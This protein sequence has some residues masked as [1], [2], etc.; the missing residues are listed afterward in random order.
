MSASRKPARAQRSAPTRTAEQ[1]ARTD[2]GPRPLPPLMKQGRTRQLTLTEVTTPAGLRVI[3][4]RKPGAP[5]IEVRLRIPFAARSGH[6]AA[7]HAARAEV[8]AETILL[9]TAD[10]DRRRIDT[11][12]G[13]VGGG[14]HAAVDPQR[15]SLAGSV[16][17]TGLPVLARILALSLTGAAYRAGD[18]AGERERLVEHL[19]IST[20]QP[21]VIARQALLRKRFGDHPAVYEMPSGPDVAAVGAAAVRGL[22]RRAV[23]PQGSTL[24]LVGDLSVK[25]AAESVAHALSIWTGEHPARVMATPPAGLGGALQAVHRAGAVQSQIRLSGPAPLR[26]DPEYPAF[27]LANLIFAGYFSSRLVENLREDKGYTYSA[28]ASAEFWP[29]RSQLSVA[30]DTNTETTAPALLETRY[31]L[32]KLTLLAPSEAEVESARNYALGTLALSLSTQAGYA[33]TLSW[34]LGAGSDA[35]WL[36]EHPARLA[37]V[38][39][40]DVADAGARWFGPTTFTGVVVGDLDRIGDQLQRLGGVTLP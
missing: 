26:S 31:E 18:V 32:A 8:L 36:R 40:D 33:S 5:I 34:L 27:Q 24:V 13:A 10:I 4:I 29:G 17:A 38:T 2:I 9:G 20:T 6:Q 22:H 19:L 23:V 3:A 11:T 35:D 1:L 14:L 15:L 39:R 25:A 16:L 30:F 7:A 12:L 28:G 37:A 21:G